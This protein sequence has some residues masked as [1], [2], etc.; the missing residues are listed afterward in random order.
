MCWRWPGDGVESRMRRDV[1]RLTKAL[2][3]KFF[4][5]N[6][7]FEYKRV[8]IIGEEFESAVNRKADRSLVDLSLIG[9]CEMLP[10]AERSGTFWSSLDEWRSKG[11]S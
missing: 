11:V 9:F 4:Q 10:L 8:A 3:A 1:D 7:E 2:F 6:C 5:R